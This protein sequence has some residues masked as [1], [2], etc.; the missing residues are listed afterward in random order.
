MPIYEYQCRKCNEKFESYR[1]LSGSDKDVACPVCGEK[2][3]RRIVSRTSADACGTDLSEEN[4]NWF[5][6]GG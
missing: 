2:G 1:G 4:N 5:F 3:P 6:S